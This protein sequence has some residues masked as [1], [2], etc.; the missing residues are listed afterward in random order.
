M[1]FVYGVVDSIKGMT[2]VFYI[3]EEI[4]KQNEEKKAERER[5]SN[6]HRSPSPVPSSAS[7]MLEEE[8]QRERFNI[9]KHNADERSLDSLHDKQKSTQPTIPFK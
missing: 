8:R 7:A 1:G 9:Q 5:R 4:H 2:L 3:D 6:A